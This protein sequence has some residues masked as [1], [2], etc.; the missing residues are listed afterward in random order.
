MASPHSNLTLVI[1]SK[2]YSSW[3][4]RPWLFLQHHG[5][6]FQERKILFSDADWR[7][8]V[9][10]LSP[11]G[12]VPLLIDG[13]IKVWES[14]AIC[15]HVADR[16]DI[17]DAW[18]ASPAAR[19]L[20]RAMACEMHAGF[21]DLRSELPFHLQRP[22]TPKAISAAA[23]ADIAR[24]RGLWRDAHARH[25]DGGD[26]LLGR[27]GIVDAMFAPVALRFVTYAVPL[28]GW[29]AQ[30]VQ[31]VLAHPAIARWRADAAGEPLEYDDSR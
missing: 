9:R 18:P 20:A 17:V 8:R 23:A 28:D 31:T 21:A 10:A 22:E 7:A 4:L 30:Y 24:I 5:V 26:W 27:F 15:E 3:S 11:S 13:E 25:G 2:T 1:G 16:H 29:E 19:A 6:V 12:R 14:L